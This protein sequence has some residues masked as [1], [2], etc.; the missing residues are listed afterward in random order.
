VSTKQ[1]SPGHGGRGFFF[2]VRKNISISEHRYAKPRL[3]I[4]TNYPEGIM[5]RTILVSTLSAAVLWVFTGFAVNVSENPEKERSR[6]GWLGVS[7]QDVTKTIAEDRGLKSEDGAH[8]VEVVDDSPADS[9]GLRKGDVIVEFAGRKIYDADDL[10]KSVSRTE[11][12]TR[13]SLI[14]V[15]N[16]ERKT[17]Q[18][19]VG[20]TP[21]RER[22]SFRMGDHPGI[23]MFHSGKGMLGLSVLSLSEQLAKYFGAPNDE[24]VLVEMVRKDSP[25]EKAG[26]MAGDVILRVGSKS[27]DEIGDIWKGLER[28]DEGDKVEIEV[29]RKGSKKTVT[30]ELE[31]IEEESWGF[32]MPSM[33][34]FQVHPHHRGDIDFDFDFEVAPNLRKIERELE[35]IGPRLE[36][37]APRIE[38]RIHEG[39]R[40]IVRTVAI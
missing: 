33:P 40:R 38:K 17:Y 20:K 21:R 2:V 29:L 28:Y 23:R 1:N 19:I 16:N 26:I 25:A 6:R 31:E 27:V 15:R 12:G 11:P 22:Y 34:G 10:A 8:I 36:R 7:I 37:L 14:V 4:K 35:E 24:G 13:T 9:I 39:V 3:T 30:I 18:V 5:K 32:R